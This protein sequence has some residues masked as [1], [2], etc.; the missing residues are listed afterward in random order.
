MDIANLEFR[1]ENLECRGEGGE[2]T[3]CEVRMV[4][5]MMTGVSLK[6]QKIKN[7]LGKKPE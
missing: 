3:P 1:N 5:G 7:M 2:M 6:I 4:S